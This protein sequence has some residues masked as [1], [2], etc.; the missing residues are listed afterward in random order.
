[1]RELLLLAVHLIVTIT[2]LLRPGGVRAVAAESLLLKQQIIIGNRS[3]RRAPNLTSLDR[4]VLGVNTL[5]I[6]P[7][8]ISK[9]SRTLNPTTLFK[10]LKA[11]V[12][13][14]YR[15]LFSSTGHWRK[16]GPK[17]PS[18][19]LIA[20][21]VEMKVRNPRS[22]CV[23]IAQQISQTFHVDV[24]KDVIRRVLA[25]QYRPGGGSSRGPSWL[26]LI[27][28]SKDSLWSVDLPLRID[29]AS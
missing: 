23:R 29:P 10:L 2:K 5:F 18:P 17:V 20:A 11:L 4:F 14:K 19:E 3:R 25:Q 16:P 21:I 27:A 15:I 7:H 6:R 9:L 28:Q 26:T 12:D 8:R 1:M 22:G 24:D 13:R